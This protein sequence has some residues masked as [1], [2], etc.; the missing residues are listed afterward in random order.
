MITGIGS[1]EQKHLELLLNEYCN[2]MNISHP[3]N[4]NMIE[5]DWKLIESVEIIIIGV[6]SFITFPFYRFPQEETNTPHFIFFANTKDFA[7]K[8]FQ[9]FGLDYLQKPLN[10]SDLKRAID[11]ALCQLELRRES[12]KLQN[13]Y[14]NALQSFWNK[15]QTDQELN[16]QIEIPVQFG[17]KL[18]HLS[19]VTYI[20][21]DGDYTVF[22]F[23]DQST[24]VSN[25]HLHDFEMD[26][27]FPS[28][29]RVNNAAIINLDCLESVTGNMVILKCKTRLT[30]SRKNMND[31]RSL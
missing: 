11:N 17:L 6:S 26:L 24:I 21:A 1:G 2:E 4:S 18:I 20:H 3:L 5:I 28:F 22:H 19:E 13:K 29:R 14:R 9:D 25:L 27:Q 16:K 31:F 23:A 12:Q 8:F 7:V 30:L 15:F 10:G